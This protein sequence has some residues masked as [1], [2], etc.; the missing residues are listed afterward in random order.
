MALEIGGESWA[1]VLNHAGVWAL[2]LARIL[3]L[4]VTAPAL[5]VPELDWRF[6]LGLAVV[7]SAVLIPVLEPS[8]APPA[9]WQGA[10]QA[11][12]SELL[13]GGVLGWSAALVVA[14]ARQAGELVAAQAGFSTATLLD[15]KTGD[16]LTPLGGLYGWIALAVF[17]A[18][19][20]PLLLVRALADSY[21]A[22]PAGRL[23]VSHETAMLAFAQVGRALALAVGAAAPPAVALV[24]AGIVVGWLSRTAPSLPFV[25]LALPI[26]SFLGLVLVM[27]GL[28][29]LAAILAGAWGT[30]PWGP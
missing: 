30:L 26:R 10:A 6:R 14:G 16:G 4:C 29:A 1:W 2:V 7:I 20:G 12:L 13:T 15:A 17:L 19:D 8:I 9:A 28:A 27:L 21:A 23:I 25:A 24:L 22:V 18:I 11:L 3:G 5:A